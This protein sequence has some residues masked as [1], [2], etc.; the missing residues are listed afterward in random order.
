MLEPSGLPGRKEDPADWRWKWSKL[1]EEVREI[2]KKAGYDSYE[3][4]SPEVIKSCC[5]DIIARKDARLLLVKVLLNIDNFLAEHAEELKA[6]AKLLI[7][8]PLVI[9]RHT[10][11]EEIPPGVLYERF[12]VPVLNPETFREWISHDEIVYA[13]VQR[14]GHF[15]KLDG[16]KLKQLRMEQGLSASEIAQKV[17]VSRR[18]VY[19]YER[20][21]MDAKSEVVEKLKDVLD[22]EDFIVRLDFPLRWKTLSILQEK[23]AIRPRSKLAKDIDEYFTRLGFQLYW[24]RKAPFDALASVLR[25][26]VSLT[27]V[28][29]PKEKRLEVRIHTVDEISKVVNRR[30]IFMVE[31][32]KIIDQIEPLE[33]VSVLTVEE[34]KK[35]EKNELK[36]LLTEGD[37]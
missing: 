22:S 23:G 19:A 16:S 25:E 37:R 7:G 18:A 24:A 32:E 12:G 28:E 5:F 29:E 26:K 13:Y 30:A 3:L 20:G 27:G 2:I 34:A 33:S 21:E 10:K 1:I 36:E 31:N 15:V 17:G 35:K 4:S 8:I 14:G 6:F 9:G 11:R